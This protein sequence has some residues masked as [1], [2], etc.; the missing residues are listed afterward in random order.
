MQ[1]VLPELDAPV[2][3]ILDPDRGVTDDEF[4]SFCGPIRSFGW[5]VPPEGRS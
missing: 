3:L 5:N 4:R 1:I 2:T